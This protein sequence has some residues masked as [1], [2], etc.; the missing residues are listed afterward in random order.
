MTVSCESCCP[1]A[2]HQTSLHTHTHEQTEQLRASIDSSSVCRL[3]G[4][5]AASTFWLIWLPAFSRGTHGT[6]TW[7]WITSHLTNCVIEAAACLLYIACCV[8]ASA[9]S[10]NQ[11]QI[12][13]K[14]IR[15][16]IPIDSMAYS[17]FLMHLTRSSSTS[18]AWN[19]LYP[20][21]LPFGAIS[22]PPS[23]SLF[24]HSRPRVDSSMVEFSNKFTSVDCVLGMALLTHTNYTP[25]KSTSINLN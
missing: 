8:A 4:R 22:F 13:A 25:P 23:L 21:R 17:D 3:Y 1:P 6:A 20:L 10:S 2:K 18:C 9:N 12:D 5:F 14:P 7:L 16:H 24:V 15:Q 19:R 11:I